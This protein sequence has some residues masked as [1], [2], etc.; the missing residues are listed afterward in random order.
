MVFHGTVDKNEVA[1]R[2][3]YKKYFKTTCCNKIQ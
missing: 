2:S 3:I 1:A